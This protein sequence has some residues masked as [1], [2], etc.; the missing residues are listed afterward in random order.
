MASLQKSFL[1]PVVPIDPNFIS[2]VHE[3]SGRLLDLKRKDKKPE[4]RRKSKIEPGEW[5]RAWLQ[6][7]DLLSIYFKSKDNANPKPVT[8]LNP[9]DEQLFNELVAKQEQ[10]IMER[11]E[12]DQ[13]QLEL[14]RRKNLPKDPRKRKFSEDQPVPTKRR[15]VGDIK[16]EDIISPSC[17]ESG[18]STCSSNEEITPF[19]PMSETYFQTEEYRRYKDAYHLHQ[20]SKKTVPTQEDQDFSDDETDDNNGDKIPG[21]DPDTTEYQSDDES[22]DD[23]IE[24]EGSS[25]EMEEENYRPGFADNCMLD[26]SDDEEE[27]EYPEE[28]QKHSVPSSSPREDNIED[29]DDLQF[30]SEVIVID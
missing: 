5:D 9:E 14:E 17:S 19:L 22:G 8:V 7:M 26:S 27:H 13:K 30:V 4:I 16:D 15:N 28:E 20:P 6:K 3:V 18:Y 1:K 12:W 29:D 21:I 23:I 2:P 24:I 25:D 10:K 11:R